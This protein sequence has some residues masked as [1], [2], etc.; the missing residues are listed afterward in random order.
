MSTPSRK[1]KSSESLDTAIVFDATGL[2][3][4]LK[5]EFPA[6]AHEVDDAFQKLQAIRQDICRLDS[7][8]ACIFKPEFTRIQTELQTLTQK[9]PELKHQPEFKTLVNGCKTVS[10]F[11][12]LGNLLKGVEGAAATSALERAVRAK[13]Q[14]SGSANKPDPEPEPEP[15]PEELREDMQL[16]QDIIKDLAQAQTTRAEDWPKA[17][18]A[19]QQA[20]D[21]IRPYHKEMAT[22]AEA[23]EQGFT[24]AVRA[25]GLKRDTPRIKKRINAFSDEAVSL[26]HQLE[27]LAAKLTENTSIPSRELDELLAQFARK[28]KAKRSAYDIGEPVLETATDFPDLDETIVV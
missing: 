1:R 22:I 3:E 14:A 26:V 10:K 8:Y 18:R 27:A 19:L 24:V 12:S 15:D 6:A 23:A 13:Y 11:V 28:I 16:I 5:Q 20:L 9:L 21:F 7:Q 25:S 17:G 4:G 2:Q